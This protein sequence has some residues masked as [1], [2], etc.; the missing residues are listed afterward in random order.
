MQAV[1]GQHC[2]SRA[3]SDGQDSHY[4][5]T[6]LDNPRTLDACHLAEEYHVQPLINIYTS[7]CVKSSV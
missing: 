6:I 5:T 7:H 2:P 4:D 3:L 1:I